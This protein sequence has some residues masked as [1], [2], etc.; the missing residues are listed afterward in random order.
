VVGRT[1]FL[2]E[3]GS[4]G[5]VFDEIGS[6]MRIY[7][8]TLSGGS[9]RDFILGVYPSGHTDQLVLKN[10]GKVGIGTEDPTEKLD[11]DGN[12]H[13]S[14]DITKDVSGGRIARATPLAYA[15]INFDGSVA[16]GTPNVSCSW[17]STNSR[18]EITIDGESY[19]WV[20][21]VTVVTV[22][23]SDPPRIA[24]TSSVGGKLL[25]NI[26]NLSGTETQSAFQFITY[27]P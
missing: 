26:Y 21:Y 18:Y 4:Y 14:G 8:E 20:N 19:L 9:G 11:V 12:I 23:D 13:V 15:F 24:T 16:S 10:D 25:V 3:T 27:K 6:A 5:L 2:E 7:S 1:A 17:N 22:T